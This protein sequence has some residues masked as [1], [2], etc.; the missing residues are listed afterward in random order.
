VSPEFCHNVP[1]IVEHNVQGFVQD[2]GIVQLERRII[3]LCDAE[4]QGKDL[5]IKVEVDGKLRCFCKAKHQEAEECGVIRDW[6]G[7]A[8][9]LDAILPE[10]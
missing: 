6:N 3:E 4:P 7:D 2:D 9:Y 1:P 10:S 5:A 8:F